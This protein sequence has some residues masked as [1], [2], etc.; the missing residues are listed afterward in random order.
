MSFENQCGSCENFYDVKGY[1]DEYP[2]SG[3]KYDK[4]HCSWYRTYYYPEESCNHYRKRNSSSPSNCYITTIVC[5][6]LGN[7]DNCD[8]LNT[9]R[10]FRGNVLQKDKKYEK[11]LFE[12]DTVGPI[13]SNNLMKEDISI[14]DKIYNSFLRPI[15]GLIKLHQYDNAIKRYTNMTRSLEEYYGIDYDLEIDKDYD[16][17][18][19]GHGHKVLKK[20]F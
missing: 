17:K 15:V 19:G 16:Y 13:I 20:D 11:I 9:L 7:D 10:D 14:I 4:G 6:R 5:N 2:F 3:G 12:Y 1:N 8:V 18:K